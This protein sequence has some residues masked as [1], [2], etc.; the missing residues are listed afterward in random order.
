MMVVFANVINFL[1]MQVS[2]AWCHF[3]IIWFD[4]ASRETQVERFQQVRVR[5]LEMEV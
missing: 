4:K 2:I 5:I 1:D 3:L